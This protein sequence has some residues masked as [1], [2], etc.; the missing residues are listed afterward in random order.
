[1][2]KA[3]NKLMSF[4]AAFAMVLSVLVAPFT[5]ANAAEDTETTESVTIHKILLTKEALGAHDK[6]KKYDGNSIKDIKDFFGD[7]NAKEIDGVY[8]KLQSLK[9]RYN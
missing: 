7:T 6:D 8:F 2:K 9:K 3:T 4:L 1:M 5:S